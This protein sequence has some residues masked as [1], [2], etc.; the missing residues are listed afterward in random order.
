MYS[1]IETII[2]C[3]I[4]SLC[5]G[6]RY[7]MVT[8]YVTP[9]VSL[10]LNYMQLHIFWLSG[11]Y[12][13]TYVTPTMSS[14]SGIVQLQA[15]GRPA[16]RMVLHRRHGK[17]P[18]TMTTASLRCLLTTTSAKTTTGDVFFII[19]KNSKKILSLIV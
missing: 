8:Y 7:V 11:M 10:L 19:G 16:W 9:F 6:N 5:I 2:Y 17:P 18:G 3:F 4:D 13:T 1:N 14:L 15:S 12:V